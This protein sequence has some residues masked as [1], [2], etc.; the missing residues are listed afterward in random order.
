MTIKVGFSPIGVWSILRLTKQCVLALV[1]RQILF[2]ERQNQY[3][4]GR[5]IRRSGIA[6]LVIVVCREWPTAVTGLVLQKN[7][8]HRSDVIVPCCISNL[9]HALRHVKCVEEEVAASHGSTGASPE[10][11]PQSAYAST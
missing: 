5:R 6:H 10:V 3:C 8:T 7:L 9:K 11:I 2:F 4:H 1:H